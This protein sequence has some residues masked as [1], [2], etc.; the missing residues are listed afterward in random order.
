MAIEGYGGIC[1]NGVV[2]GN[3]G[4][5]AECTSMELLGGGKRWSA[6]GPDLVIG[7][8]GKGKGKG[9]EQG[10]CSHERTGGFALI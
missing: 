5:V 4:G 7:W 8:K 9:R 10:G 6:A 1:A 2:E 3:G